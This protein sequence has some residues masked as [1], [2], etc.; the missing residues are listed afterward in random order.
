MVQL[1]FQ[2]LLTSMDQFDL[3]NVELFL[4]IF[5]SLQ[6]VNSCHSHIV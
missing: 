6:K 3:E 2:F 1:L 4:N 5:T